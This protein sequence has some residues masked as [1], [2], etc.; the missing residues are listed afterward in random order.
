MV[1]THLDVID[2]RGSR[3][4]IGEDTA[5]RIAVEHLAARRAGRV[6]REEPT[7]L[8]TH[9]L[10]HDEATWSFLAQFLERSRAHA[11]VRWLAADDIFEPA[12]AMPNSARIA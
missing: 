8:L 11:A 6:D 9:H 2:W 3:G 5:L 12:P 7:G 1:N 4:F 10:A